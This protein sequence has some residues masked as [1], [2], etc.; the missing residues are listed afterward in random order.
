MKGFLLTA[1]IILGVLT[2]I[3]GGIYPAIMATKIEPAEALLPAAR[4]AK[5]ISVIEK[6]I[7]PERHI[8]ELILIGIAMFSAFSLFLIVMPLLS[9]YGDPMLVF[10]SLFTSLLVMLVSVIVIF[11]GIFPVIV[12]GIKKFFTIFDKIELSLSTINL[13]RRRKRTLLAF[14]MIASAVSALM[15]IG[16]LTLTQEK[17]IVV[18]MKTSA[19]ADIV[20]YAQEPVPLNYTKVIENITGVKAVCPVTNSYSGSVGD[21]VFWE[22][23]TVNMYGIDPNEYVSSSYV[24]EFYTKADSTFQLLNEN[25]TVIISEGLADRLGLR[26]GDEMRLD[27]LKKTFVL[28]VVGV[29]PT[30][31]GFSFTRFK[32]KA[33]GS[34]MLL[35]IDTLKNITG[36]QLWANR[37]LISVEKGYNISTVLENVSQIVGADYDVQVIAV[38]DYIERASESIEQLRDLLGT[39]LSFAIIIA[40]LGQM[41]S[42]VTT[43][44]EREWE[45]AVLRALGSKR[46]QVALIFIIESII[47]SILGFIA[48]FI[49][50][51]VVSYELNYSNNLM[52]EI[53]IPVQMPLDTMTTAFTLII[54]PTTILSLVM[55]WLYT[56]KEIAIILKTAETG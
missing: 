12:K 42:I 37:F 55:S 9:Y 52:S 18:S 19:G 28:K 20:I 50:S 31:P 8:S 36:R 10:L 53:V 41:A 7:D 22:S 43:I 27:Y 35:S 47:L 32:N 3:L 11:A 21:I 24:K 34:D 49:S 2:A 1:L 23:T 38:Q 54:I 4:R 33:S 6:K 46:V 26:V 39:L 17:S 44:R 5:E 16:S 45:I 29:I 30:A 13:L 56:K 14:F 48:G 25:F 15:L 40:V 51:L